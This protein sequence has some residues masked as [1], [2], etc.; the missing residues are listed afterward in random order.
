VGAWL[1]VAGQRVAAKYGL[2]AV[3]IAWA[4][5]RLLILAW[6]N[7]DDP[8]AHSS[9]LGGMLPSLGRDVGYC[10]EWSSAW[11]EGRLPYRDVEIH[12]PPGAVVLFTIPRLFASSFE[13]YAMAFAAEM[14]VFEALALA[15]VWR[16]VTVLLGRERGRDARPALVFV[17]L[18]Y[19]G[20]SALLGRLLVRRFDVAV[21]ALMVAFVLG[22]VSGRRALWAELVLALGI[23]VKL[24]PAMLVPLYLVMLHRREANA[25]PF[26]RWLIS[27]GW[28][29]L[30]R[31]GLIE[32]ALLAPFVLMARGALLQIPRFQ[33]SRGLHIESFPGSLL[34]FVQSVHDF[35]VTRAE[36]HGAVELFHPL[37]D[38][39]T[40]VSD[41]AVFA[42]VLAIAIVCARRLRDARGPA[43]D[44]HIFIG[45]VVATL[46]SV[47]SLSKLF[48][49]QYV[50]WVAALFPLT[51]LR[52]VRRPV[53]L[54]AVVAF[55]LTG[56]L[57]LF[58]Y[59][60][61]TAMGFVS[62]SMLLA[63]NLTLLWL[64][65]QLAAPER[66][67]AAE[68]DQRRARLVAGAVALAVS[69]W[70][71]VTNLTPLREGELWSDIRIGREI[72]LGHA[73]PRTDSFTA[74]GAGMAIAPAGWLSGVTF[75][76]CL[77]MAR[78]WAL[79]L[80]QPAVAGGA[81]LLLL[82]SL[83][84]DARRSAVTV[85]FLLLAI[86]AVASRTDVRHQMF[87]PLAL[88]AVGF[89]L[90]RWRRSGRLRDLAW[91]V[92]V[93]VLW[94]NLNGEALSAPLLVG[95]LAVV[96]GVS[97]LRS[98]GAVPDGDRTLGR[99]DAQ[100][101]GGLAVVLFLATLCNPYGLGGVPWAPAWED[102]DG[103]WSL[104]PAVIH[105]YPFWS[106]AALAVALWLALAMRWSSGR[107]V[108]DLGIAA[109]ATFMSLH[110]ARFL[111]YVAILGFPIVVRSLRALGGELLTAPARRWLGLELALSVALLAAGASE[112]YSFSSWVHRPPGVGVT[113]H[114][115][116][117]ELRL[118]KESG[119]TGAIFNDRAVGGLISFNLAP[120]VRPVIDSRADAAGSER[121]AEYQRARGS[122][123]AFLAYLE[124]YDVRFVLLRVEQENLP[125]LQMLSG[126]AR[127]TLMRDSARY[128]L[129]AR[130]D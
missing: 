40:G 11:L 73:F 4:V 120:Q 123:A 55:A 32:A 3:V 44:R 52:G 8:G 33:A 102:G 86:H 126:D 9:I 82:L 12:Y 59:S 111:P 54:A 47:M 124:R 127:W 50:L 103:R 130:N 57:Y 114:L 14:I 78:A 105:Q 85:P 129:F 37:S 36:A 42:A 23:W 104:A 125:M 87:S 56:Y 15:L 84:R 81:A 79:C 90:E 112:G 72:L 45:G 119:R 43:D 10:Y 1:S 91:L 51:Q 28:R 65:W 20:L 17:A 66:A 19:V 108:L 61:L 76:S 116:F 83:R 60:K 18:A 46:L 16:L 25:A 13:G 6:V 49:P 29:P 115:P 77:G 38:A 88:A 67:P 48:S 34:A 100:V 35:G 75:F 5:T 41:V 2:A 71:V 30:A 22:V 68:G 62:A 70:I 69:A 21:G 63:R 27:A 97:V 39:L 96:L 117:D 107:L 64:I 93:Q 109:F 113:A 80:L 118:V 58:D 121:W 7:S 99:R 101:L 89:A 53:V 31:I 122:R 74:T 94:A 95:W 110:A 106:C 26:W 98:G 128:G 92:P 24:M